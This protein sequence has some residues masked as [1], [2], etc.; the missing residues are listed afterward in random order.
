MLKEKRNQKPQDK[1]R[2]G[3]VFKSKKTLLFYIIL[4]FFLVFVGDGA[5]TSLGNAQLIEENAKYRRMKKSK[6]RCWACVQYYVR[7]YETVLEGN[8]ASEFF[9]LFSFPIYLASIV[10]TYVRQR[11]KV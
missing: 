9:E 10:C 2:M 5:S 4:F 8:S 7:I 6:L 3:I 11:I 1:R